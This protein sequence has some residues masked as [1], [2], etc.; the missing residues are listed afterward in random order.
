MI[1]QCLQD[2]AIAD[3]PEVFTEMEGKKVESGIH[4][5]SEPPFRQA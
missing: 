3:R 4:E 5:S 1:S 2:R